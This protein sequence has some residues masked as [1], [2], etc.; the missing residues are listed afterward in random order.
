MELISE[1]SEIQQIILSDLPSET[2]NLT[3]IKSEGSQAQYVVVSYLWSIYTVVRHTGYKRLHF[4]HNG[5]K[6][7]VFLTVGVRSF[8]SIVTPD[9][10]I[11][12]KTSD[13]TV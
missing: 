3:A 4:S 5:C 1:I 12:M 11:P 10:I 8:C 2:W 6:F 13:P 7:Y 9:I